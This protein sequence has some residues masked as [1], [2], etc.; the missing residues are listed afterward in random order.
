[1]ARIGAIYI[2]PVCDAAYATFDE[3]ND[4][5]RDH[6]PDEDV[7]WICDCGK[8][9]RSELQA[10]LHFSKCRQAKPGCINCNNYDQDLNVR[11]A[12]CERDNLSSDMSACSE[13]RKMKVAL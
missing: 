12:P 10:L 5:L 9:F 13:Y 4:C 6:C 7:G 3:A 8:A 11:H 1:M 2:C